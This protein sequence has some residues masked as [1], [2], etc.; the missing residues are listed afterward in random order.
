MPSLDPKASSRRFSVDARFDSQLAWLE[1]V[2][3]LAVNDHPPSHSQLVRR[4]VGLLVKHTTALIEAG[5]QVGLPGPNAQAAEAERASLADYSRIVP[6]AM[7]RNMVNAQ[8]HL[9]GWLASLATS[10]AVGAAAARSE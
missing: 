6:A 4:A 1:R 10:P 2:A 7:P 5:Q 8:G 9:Q 3:V